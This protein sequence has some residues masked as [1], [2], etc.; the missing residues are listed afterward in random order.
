MIIVK[1]TVSYKYDTVGATQ[2]GTNYDY[3]GSALTTM[4]VFYSYGVQFHQLLSSDYLIVELCQGICSTAAI[5]A[6]FYAG[7]HTR[8]H[9]K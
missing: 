7:N 9:K 3:N 8:K 2:I 6:V 5:G 4:L 1:I